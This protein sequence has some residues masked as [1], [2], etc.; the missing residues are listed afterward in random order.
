MGAVE[1]CVRSL[2]LYEDEDQRHPALGR[3][4][5]DARRPVVHAGHR[6]RPRVVVMSAPVVTELHGPEGLA[7][8][9]AACP[10]FEPAVAALVNG[11]ERDE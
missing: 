10:D 2:R 9:A 4:R 3:G 1:L 11:G 5:R 7:A 6:P 8:W